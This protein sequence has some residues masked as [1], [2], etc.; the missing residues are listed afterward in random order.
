MKDSRLYDSAGVPWQG[1]SFEQNPWGKDDGSADANYLNLVRSYKEGVTNFSS[2]VSKIAAIRFLTPLIANLGEADTGPHGKLV[3]KSADLSIVS[4]AAP[5]GS[6]AL[7]AFSSVNA[8]HSWN[9]ASR[10]VPV[11]AQKLMLAAA[12]EGNRYVVLDAGT[13]YQLVLRRSAISAIAQGH[14]WVS[15]DENLEVE[16]IVAGSVGDAVT[17]FKL[18]AADTAS[19]LSKPELLIYL[20]VPKGLN[21]SQLDEIIHTVGKKLASER[22]RELVDSVE[23]KLVLS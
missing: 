20:G 11:S 9:P 3:D 7:P 2:V 22:F 18:V 6:S 12:S 13:E 16:K 8:M 23:L 1:R 10:P 17:N 4:V 15:P 19:D 21:R 14:V 5:D